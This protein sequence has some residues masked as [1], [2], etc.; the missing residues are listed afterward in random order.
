MLYAVLVDEK[1]RDM[2]LPDEEGLS[3][4]ETQVLIGLVDDETDSA[5][6]VLGAG[7]APEEDDHF[8]LSIS[9][10]RLAKGYEDSDGERILL[11]FLL[12]IAPSLGCSAVLCAGAFMD[13]A[14][15]ER[16]KMLTELGFC[17]PEEKLPLYTFTISDLCVKDYKSDMACI[18]LS[19]AKEDQWDEFVNET[20]DYDFFVM[21]QD[22]YEQDLSIFLTDDDKK[23]Q[24]GALISMGGEV[25]FVDAIAAF[26]G[27]QE[28]LINDL[29][30]WGAEGAKSR[31]PG[32][33]Q[34][35]IFLPGGKA[36]RDILMAATDKKAKRV[37]NLMTYT[38]ETPVH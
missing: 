30:L 16:E 12:D 31:L 8:S 7:V 21:D 13:E 5:C 36:Y 3:S 24:A 35:D 37:G 26:G 18:R 34:V 2:F 23:V 15:A 20:S 4:G 11:N 1:G 28:G 29:I 19:D 32:D 33:T 25:L 27:D 22:M 38:Y 6:G 17:E 10:I 9:F 14:D